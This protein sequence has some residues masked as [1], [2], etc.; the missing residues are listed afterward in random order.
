M[1]NKVALGEIDLN[2]QKVTKKPPGFTETT[3]QAIQ[4]AAGEETEKRDELFEPTGLGETILHPGRELFEI[5]GIQENVPVMEEQIPIPLSP[6]PIPEEEHVAVTEKIADKVTEISLTLK[7]AAKKLKVV[8]KRKL[9][10]DEVKEIPDSVMQKRIKQTSELQ[11]SDIERVTVYNKLPVT[12][13][14]RTN[15]RDMRKRIHNSI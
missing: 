10:I 12:D 5:T 2:R 15:N 6:P 13:L 11:P 7:K 1:F 4:R 8:P 3:F 9:I 14:F